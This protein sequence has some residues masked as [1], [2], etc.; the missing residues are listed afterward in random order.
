MTTPTT[1]DPILRQVPAHL[2]TH[3]NATSLVRWLE[4]RG[5]QPSLLAVEE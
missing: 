1:A 4:D 2:L 3:D 5:H